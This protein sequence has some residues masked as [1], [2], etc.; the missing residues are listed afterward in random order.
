MIFILWINCQKCLYSTL[1]WEDD[2]CIV[3][4]LSKVVF[5]YENC[6]IMP[7]LRRISGIAFGDQQ[8]F[9]TGGWIAAKFRSLSKDKNEN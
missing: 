6:I 8:A 5:C 7:I 2:I 3:V 1:G 4:R 9:R